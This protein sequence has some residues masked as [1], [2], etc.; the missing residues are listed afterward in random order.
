M[1]ASFKHITVKKNGAT[2]VNTTPGFLFGAGVCGGERVSVPI[3]KSAR[4]RKYV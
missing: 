3:A 2:I 1:A 4:I